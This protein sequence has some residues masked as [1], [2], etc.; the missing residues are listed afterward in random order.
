MTVRDMTMLA[1]QKVESRVDRILRDREEAQVNSKDDVLLGFFGDYVLH[2]D[3]ALRHTRFIRDLCGSRDSSDC[4]KQALLAAALSNRANQLG[5]QQMAAE[6]DATYGFALIS[7]NAALQNPAEL[8]KDST[9]AASWLVGMCELLSGRSVLE[10]HH[11]RGRSQLLR[12]RGAEQFRSPV[13]KCLYAVTHS[14][15]IQHNLNLLERP[16][17]EAAEYLELCGIKKPP[18][19]IERLHLRTAYW[20]AEARLLFESDFQ[21]PWSQL[22][23]QNHIQTGFAIDAG[24]QKWLDTYLSSDTWGRRTISLP[25][26]SST[27]AVGQ[28]AYTYHD[29]WIANIW[30]GHYSKRMHLHNLLLHCLSLLDEHDR[31]R[32]REAYSR[33]IV[34]NMVSGVCASVPFMLYEIDSKGNETRA[35]RKIALCGYLLLCQLHMARWSVEQGSERE[36]WIIATLEFIDQSMGIR[37][38]RVLALKPRKEPWRLV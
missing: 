31:L 7:L 5:H 20:C 25:S 28:E 21:H 17:E 15:A 34:E 30:L 36:R 12:L 35:R 22:Q 2:S 37:S 38:A 6:A 26:E 1:E 11:H 16:I 23:L 24:Y 18:L 13:G 3:V 8:K 10:K 27:H 14:L 19:Q 29:L 4:F 32:M 33:A 9:L